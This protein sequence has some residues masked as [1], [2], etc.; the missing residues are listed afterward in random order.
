MFNWDI[1][2]GYVILG[3]IGGAVIVSSFIDRV[4]I[5]NG[6]EAYV[7]VVNRI[8]KLGVIGVC[9]Y[10]GLSFLNLVSDMTGLSLPYVKEVL[11]FIH[12]L[13]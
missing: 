8:L 12:G 1:T 10:V 7:P 4:L 5:R 13:V 9:G 3:I 6:R 2:T 11:R